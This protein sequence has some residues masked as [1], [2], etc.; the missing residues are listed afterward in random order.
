MHRMDTAES[1]PK[2]ALNRA[3]TLLPRLILGA[4]VFTAVLLPSL[5]Q[6]LLS[7]IYHYL[8]QSSFYRSSMFE[9]ALTVLYYAV[10][11]QSYTYKFAHTPHLRL[12]VRGKAFNVQKNRPRLP[13]MRL[14]NE[15][16]GEILLYIAPL[17]T[18]D[19]VMIKKF[20]DVSF[21]E[22]RRT[23]GYAPI[24]ASAI[25]PHMSSSFLKP[26]LHNFSLSSPLQVERA[27]PTSP[28]SSRRIVLE[29]IASLLIYDATFFATH[30]AFHRL[31]FLARF[32]RPHHTHTEIHPQITN[33]LSV[34][35]R[36]SLVMLANFS[37]NIIGSHVL[38]RTCFIPL[39]IDLL[40]E[41]HS[42]MDMDW[43]YHRLLPD[44][45]ASGPRL[46]ADHHRT[47]GGGYAPFFRLWDLL[48]EWWEPEVYSK[49]KHELSERRE[50]E[51]TGLQHHEV[52]S[53][54]KVER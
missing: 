27:L 25:T 37:L 48:L 19:L 16:L 18:M 42:G 13:R 32:H 24:E 3:S 17:L 26:T 6:P 30:L 44:G 49:T 5:Y 15:R 53:I 22:M 36:L 35:E 12:D 28:P 21:N 1:S 23:G 51:S 2:A 29:L 39:F 41:I 8:Y 10:I 46:H 20:A 9:T 34:L 7:S 31:D 4:F 40:V 38:T 47:G 33:R 52:H 54:P 14:L 45:W 11:E 50:H 43:G